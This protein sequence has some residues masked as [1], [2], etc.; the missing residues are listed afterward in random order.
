MR[1]VNIDFT[2]ADAPVN[3]F[4]GYTGEANNTQLSVQLPENLCS[5]D[6][7]Y[8]RIHFKTGARE[9]I[10]SGKLYAQEGV[11]TLTLWYE[12]LRNSGTLLMQ[13]SAYDFEDNELVRLGKTPIAA[14]KIRPSLAAGMEANQEIYGLEAEFEEL[15][16][17]HSKGDCSVMA[18]TFTDLPMDVRAGTL[19]LVHSPPPKYEV[20]SL[21]TF[22]DGVNY[23]RIYLNPYPPRPAHVYTGD[24]DLESITF[25]NIETGVTFPYGC[26]YMF[27]AGG[28]AGIPVVLQV[29]TT[30][31]SET[32]MFVYTWDEFD[33]DEELHVGTGW[34]KVFI[35]FDTGDLFSITPITAEELPVIEPAGKC[36]INSFY[37]SYFI[38]AQ[39]YFKEL[40]D[41]LYIFDGSEWKPFDTVDTSIKPVGLIPVTGI[42]FPEDTFT[43][44]VGS[45]IETAKARTIPRLAVNQ[46][47]VYSIGDET[48][49]SLS[50]QTNDDDEQIPYITG[51]KAGTTTLTATTEDGGFHKTRT[52]IVQEVH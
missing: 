49:F 52:I 6:I 48:L 12:L 16:R 4:A 19:A 37:M 21:Q 29:I 17:L 15:I 32:P 26:S 33:L 50:W 14:L 44:N 24:D 35:D 41:A 1:T 7:D 28:E 27:F 13:V 25:V 43:C 11:I 10:R 3:F 9:N 36:Q 39:S 30:L 5:E 38:S 23:P 47:I 40:L 20:P 45:M 18:D 46:N 8:Y 34:H 42:D 31:G 22:I 51:L 2:G